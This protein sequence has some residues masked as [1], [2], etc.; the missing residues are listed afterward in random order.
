MF[1]M[2]GLIDMPTAESQPDGQLSLTLGSFAGTTRGTL[3]FQLTPRL[4]GSFRYTIL[5]NWNRGGFPTFYD[6]SFDLHYQL[7]DEGRY[8]P[9]V[10]VGLRDF[11]GTGIYSSEYLVATKRITRSLKLT[12]GIGWGRL[13]TRNSFRNPLSALHSSFNI[14]PT[15]FGLG[16]AP[17]IQHWFRG[18]AALFGGVEW[19]TPIKGLTVKAEYSSDTYRPETVLSSIFNQRSAFNFGVDYRLGKRTSLSAYY[20]YG[21][22]IGVRA[23]FALDPKESLFPGSIEPAPVP[24]FRRPEGREKGAELRRD[25]SWTGQSDAARIL[26]NN[27]QL[28]LED[29]GFIIESASITGHRAE[30][31]VRNKI[32]DIESQ[33]IGRIARRM[34]RVFPVS[35]DTFV[36]TPVV[37]GM[38]VVSVTIQRQDLE[39]FENDPDGIAKSLANAVLSDPVPLQGPVVRQTGL[40]PHFS[41]TIGH[42]SQTSYFDPQQPF[43]LDVGIRGRARLDIAP[44]LSVSGSIRRKA[45]GNIDQTTRGSNSTIPHVR[46]DTPNYDRSG[47]VKLTYLTADYYFRPARNLYGHFSVGYIERMF[48]GASA[49]LLW[50]PVDSRLAL[51]GELSLVRQRAFNEGFGFRNYQVL[52]GHVSAYYELRNGFQAKVDVGRYLAGDLGATFTLDREFRNGWKVGAFFTLTNVPF[53]TFGEGSFDKGLRFTVPLS[54]LTGLPTRQSNSSVL[55]PITR[56]GGAV[57][58]VRNRLYPQIRDYHKNALEPV[59]GRFWR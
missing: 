33:A 15:G 49:E 19:V 42:Y 24:V 25:T 50:K 22:E 18:P 55:R 48:G 58:N 6:R 52:T 27:L 4:A 38:P 54:W 12:G 11:V 51:G 5:Q 45:F 57:L 17:T 30:V 56:D 36:I 47:G 13:G 43:R 2:T 3:A 34:T 59:W 41:W 14:R 1:G 8:L 26:M 23:T 46:T 35:V 39:D 53:S 9:A 21:S 16:G 31:R 32:Y 7:L 28:V 10:A 44:G 40:F 29:E 20:L 37:D